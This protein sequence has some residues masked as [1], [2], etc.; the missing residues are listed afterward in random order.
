MLFQVL[1]SEINRIVKGQKGTIDVRQVFSSLPINCDL[2]MLF[3]LIWVIL[4]K[5]KK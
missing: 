1:L 4:V 3:C 2:R 5:Y